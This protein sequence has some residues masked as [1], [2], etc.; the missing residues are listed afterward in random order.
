MRAARDSNIL[1]SVIKTIGGIKSEKNSL[2]ELKLA[3][4]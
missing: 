3:K 1:Q 4:N 2:R